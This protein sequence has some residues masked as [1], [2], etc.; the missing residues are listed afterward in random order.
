VATATRP[1]GRA[2]PGATRWVVL[3]AVLLV[4]VGLA[5]GLGVLV[6]RQ[7]ALHPSVAGE[8]TRKPTSTGRRGGLTDATAERPQQLQEK[9]TFYQT[10]TAPLGPGR[11]QDNP[12]GA[13]KPV[14]ALVSPGKSPERRSD[15]SSS[16]QAAQ[17]PSRLATVQ[18]TPLG[19]RSETHIASF[20]PKEAAR[21]ES[22]AG[23]TVQV[24]V[25]SALQQA[26]S[27]RKLL[28]DRGFEAQ[29]SPMVTSNGQ[30]RYRVRVG[31]FRS[32]DE[33]AR[34]A[35]RVRSDRSLTANV[36]AR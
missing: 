15:G 35:E 34:T 30:A 26:V 1:R 21:Q 18:N 11:S 8:S 9:L 22:T 20:E 7:G 13:T 4:I 28:A 31:A 2:Q 14:K 24:G 27:L 12:D 25:F 10:L 5:F 36:T 32:R 29:I 23:W 33:A 17:D 3:G 19:E 16:A 6:G